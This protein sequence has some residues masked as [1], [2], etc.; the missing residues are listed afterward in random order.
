MGMPGQPY[1][2]AGDVMELEIEGLGRQ[3]QTVG[4]A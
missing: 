2:R 3:R 4:Q 1:L